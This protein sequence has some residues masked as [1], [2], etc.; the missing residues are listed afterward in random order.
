MSFIEIARLY[1]QKTVKMN[2]KNLNT[3]HRDATFI[4]ERL[5][6]F[7]KAFGPLQAEL[8]C[9]C[10]LSN[11]D[12]EIS[13]LPTVKTVIDKPL[14]KNSKIKTSKLYSPQKPET[15]LLIASATEEKDIVSDTELK[16]VAI[17]KNNQLVSENA[18]QTPE[19][20]TPSNRRVSKEVVFALGLLQESLDMDDLTNFAATGEVPKGWNTYFRLLKLDP[21]EF[22]GLLTTESKMEMKFLDGILN[23]LIGE[24]ILFQV[25]QVIHGSTGKANIQGLRSAL[26]LS[27]AGDD[28]ISMLEIL[29]NYPSQKVVLEGMRLVKA[30]K[31]FAKDGIVKTGTARLED[32]LID[33]QEFGAKEDCPKVCPG[34]NTN[35]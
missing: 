4:M 9:G 24:Y 23:N 30:A 7:L 27:A 17:L 33:L 15:S 22:R 12:S 28:K 18:A 1:P 19:N 10:N 13:K 26:I 29:Q 11:N 34:R 8:I 2:L 3:V 32:L 14:N 21:E 16:P 35:S 31:T 6:K 20:S 25:G 5:D